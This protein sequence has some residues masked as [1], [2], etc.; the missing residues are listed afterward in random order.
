MSQ[1]SMTPAEGG[2]LDL[3]KAQFRFCRLAQAQEGPLLAP[4]RWE[5][6]MLVS[7]S[8]SQVREAGLFAWRDDHVLYSPS[9]DAILS[10]LSVDGTEEAPRAR[11]DM[12]SSSLGG[13]DRAMRL[14]WHHLRECRCVHCRDGRLKLLLDDA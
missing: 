11:L 13:D 6:D 2:V 14:G 12:R 3:R 7:L 8:F 5:T 10:V 9:L 4:R 1:A